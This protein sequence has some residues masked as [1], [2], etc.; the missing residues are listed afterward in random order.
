M[1][2]STMMPA[3]KILKSSEAR[4]RANHKYYDNNKPLI[5]QIAKNYHEKNRL[6]INRKKRERYYRNKELKQYID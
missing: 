6:E 4:L 3:S 1:N 2:T 5:L